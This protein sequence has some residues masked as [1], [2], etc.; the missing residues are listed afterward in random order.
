MSLRFAESKYASPFPFRRR[1]IFLS[2]PFA[3]SLR[4]K[5][6][7]G[8]Y[9]IPSSFPQKL[10][11]IE[12]G[13]FERRNIRCKINSKRKEDEEE[14][15]WRFARISKRLD[16]GTSDFGSIYIFKCIL[17]SFTRA[18]NCS[19]SG[20]RRDFRGCVWASMRT[21]EAKFR[22]IAHKLVDAT[23]LSLHPFRSNSQVLG[24]G[25]SLNRVHF[26]PIDTQFESSRLTESAL[27]C[28]CDQTSFL[29]SFLRLRPRE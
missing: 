8:V 4:A 2:P 22:P 23:S 18:R 14:I 9:A 1:S 11:K 28:H 27:L 17:F 15:R 13:L 19:K 6:I 10:P 5:T 7:D 26:A 29:S 16:F 3:C 25:I 21:E 20:P 24:A 12:H